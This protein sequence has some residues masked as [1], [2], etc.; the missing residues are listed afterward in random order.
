M[1]LI[2]SAQEAVLDRLM[3]EIARDIDEA[4][5]GAVKDAA[6]FAVAQGRA[7]IAAAGFPAR[8]RT[9]LQSRFFP[10]KGGDPAAL[11]F[12]TI[13]FAGVFERG[14]TI[15]GRPLLWLPLERNLPAVIRSPRQYG[16]K[17]VSVNVAGKPPL[18]FDAGNRSLGP[19]FVGVPQVTIRKRLDLYSIFA[20]AAGRMTEFYEQRIKGRG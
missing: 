15:R 20:L 8:W 14:V 9:A 4:R 6:A 2:F 10:N 13:P 11:I 18:L 5:A 1:K 7:N 19:L 12:D 3:K 16:R 17:L